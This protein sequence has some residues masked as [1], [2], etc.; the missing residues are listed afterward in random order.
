ML[1][2]C[3]PIVPASTAA[4]GAVAAPAHAAPAPRPR[5]KAGQVIA[6]VSDDNPYRK[7]TCDGV[8]ESGVLFSKQDN[9]GTPWHACLANDLAPG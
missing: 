9:R 3:V 8:V 7:N 2:M 1:A 5:L 4:L 6:I